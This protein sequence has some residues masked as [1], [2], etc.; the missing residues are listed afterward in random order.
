M[1]RHGRALDLQ[2]FFRPCGVLMITDG[3][4]D[5]QIFKVRLTPRSIRRQ[6]LRSHRRRSAGNTPFHR[7]TPAEDRQGEPVRTIH[8]TPSTHIRLSRPV[9]PVWSGRPMISGAIHPTAA[10]LKTNRSITTPKT[11]SVRSLQSDLLLKGNP[12][13]PHNLDALLLG[14]RVSCVSR[15]MSRCRRK[16]DRSQLLKFQEP[17]TCHAARKVRCVEAEEVALDAIGGVEDAA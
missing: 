1:P 12:K 4:I 3:G 15:P 11:A 9:D 10:S 8:S 17:A 16:S 2:T 7:Q 6:T 14:L 13:S 5:D